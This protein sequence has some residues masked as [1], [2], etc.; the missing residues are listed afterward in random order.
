MNQ[1]TDS[2]GFDQIQTS[3]YPVIHH[4]SQEMS[5]EVF[6]A[7]HAQPE[8]TNELFQKLLD[9]LQIIN[10]E[11]AKYINSSSW[12]RPIFF[13]D[14]EEHSVQYKEYLANSSNF[15]IRQLIREQCCIEVCEKQKQ[16]MEDTLLELLEKKQE[17]KNVVEKLT[18]HGT[19]IGRSLQNFRV[20]HKK[21]SISL[22]N[23]SQISS[24]NAITPV[25]PTED[26]EYSLSMRYENLSTPSETESDEVNK[27]SL[28]N[29]LP[30]LS[31]YKVTSDDEN[32]CDVP[33]CED[34]STFDVC[35]DHSK[36]LFDSSNDDISND[37]DDAFEDI[38]YVKA[39]PLDSELVSLEKENDET[40]SGSTT[41]HANNSLPEYDSFCFVIK[42]DQERLTCVVMK[43]ISNGSS[44]DPLLEEVDLFLASDNSIP[45]GIE[46]F[47]YD[48]KRDIYFLEELLVDDSISF[49]KNELSDFDH[50]DDPS[51]LHP[52][53]EPSDVEFFFDFKPNS[54]EVISA[55][56]NN[57]Y[58]LN[59]DECF[60]LGGEINVFANVEDDD[61]FSFIFIIRIFL[62][63]LIY[64]EVSPLLLSAGS[65]DTIFDPGIST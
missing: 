16:N 28:E 65:K 9:D 61:Y 19:R 53:S 18:K 59:E 6:Q 14:D 10:E 17:V 22:N 33:I 38:K 11:L 12:N 49:P 8:D 25:S 43:D 57:I 62:P 35:E 50:Q 45:S 32:E 55:V 5:K 23:T 24:V 3:Q 26:P 51:F 36:I 34:S 27:S 54:G 41:T 4:P 44:N 1:N 31:E 47:D 48:S 60:D 21:S 20:I 40:R 52:P 42:P 56:M 7:K 30:I 15:N 39:S 2:S 58:E 37:D 64:P 46:N 13:S 29:L 63:Y